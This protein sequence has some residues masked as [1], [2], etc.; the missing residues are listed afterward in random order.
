MK[1]KPET[2]FIISGGAGKNIIATA[3]V[4]ALKKADPETKI[5]I[6]T[7]HTSMWENHPLVERILNMST[8]ANLYPR[9]IKD[10]DSRIIA[11]DPYLTE[12][13]VYRRGHLAEAYCDMADVAYNGELPQMYFTDEEK[14]SIKAKLPQDDKPLFFIQTNGGAQNQEYPISWMRDMPLPI[15]Q[16]IVD[17]MNKK[18][19]T[20]VHLRREDQYALENTIRL[21]TN[22]RETVCALFFSEKRLFIDSIFQHASAALK[23]PSTVVWG[24]NRPEIFGYD[25][26]TNILPKVEEKYRH[27]IDSYLD[28]WNITGSLHECPFDTNEI[29]DTKQILASLS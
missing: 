22:L 21:D 19:Y 8:E 7:P 24:G 16:E 9:Y 11:N 23:L 3:F 6:I 1:H 13:F 4:E 12:F 5:S 15:A 2:F 14:E 26:H 18:G 10:T 25:M 28:K 27:Y 29:Y 20:T 17:A